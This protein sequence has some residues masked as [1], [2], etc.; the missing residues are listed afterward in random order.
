MHIKLIDPVKAIQTAAWIVPSQNHGMKRKGA[1]QT[2][3]H[4][5]LQVLSEMLFKFSN[6]F[7]EEK[8]HWNYDIN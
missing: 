2:V 5:N 4:P 7:L 1:C 3:I 6:L 8:R